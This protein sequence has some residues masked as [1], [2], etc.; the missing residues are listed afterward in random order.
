MFHPGY[1]MDSIGGFSHH[2]AGG[3][4]VIDLNGFGL[5]FSTLQPYLANV[6]GNVVIAL[7]A[8]TVLTITGVTIAQLQESDFVF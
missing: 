6:A 7:D 2:G 4:D 3:T 8:A 5:N 1:G